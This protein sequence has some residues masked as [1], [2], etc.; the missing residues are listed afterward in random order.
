M[1]I[2]MPVHRS[3]NIDQVDKTID[4]TADAGRSTAEDVARGARAVAEEATQAGEHAARA[5]ADLSRESAA[6]VRD[7]VLSS[8]QSAVQGFQRVTDQFTQLLGSPQAEEL[9]RR[10]SQNVEAVSQASTVIAHGFQEASREWFGLAQNQIAKNM[11]AFNRLAGCRT[12]QDMVAVQA[13]LIRDNLQQTIN[14]SRRLTELSAR[15]AGDAARTMQASASN[16]AAG[17]RRIV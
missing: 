9:A 16:N 11:D 13:E 14:T 15:I 12:V 5:G 3:P 10:S 7:N 17:A 1:R 8:A 4:K 2:E 6:T